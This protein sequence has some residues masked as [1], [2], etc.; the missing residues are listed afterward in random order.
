MKN[1]NY[2]HLTTLNLYVYHS[3]DKMSTIGKKN[4]FFIGMISRTDQQYGLMENK[5]RELSE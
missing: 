2:Y 4:E 1:E 3:L 5:H